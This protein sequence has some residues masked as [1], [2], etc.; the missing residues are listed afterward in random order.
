MAGNKDTPPREQGKTTFPPEAPGWLSKPNPEKGTEK[1]AVKDPGRKESEKPAIVGS[2]FRAKDMRP[3][4]NAAESRLTRLVK[5]RVIEMSG[6]LAGLS[7]VLPAGAGLGTLG[8]P[9]SFPTELQVSEEQQRYAMYLERLVAGETHPRVSGTRR[10]FSGRLLRWLITVLMFLAVGLP[11][12]S[13]VQVAPTSFPSTDKGA[14]AQVIEQLQSNVPVLVVFDYDPALSG[15]M[16]AL[17]APAMN[18]LLTKKIPLVLISTS[19]TGPVLAEHFIQTTLLGNVG[20]IQSGEQYI[21]LG[22]LAGGPAGMSYFADSPAEAVPLSVDGKF[23]WMEGFLQGI[24]VLRN[25][26]AIIILTD[27]ADTGRNWI[28]QA[29]PHLGDV[30]MVMITSAQAGPMIRPYLD[31]AQLKGFVTGLSDAKIYEQS[32]NHPGLAHH[33]WNSFSTGMLMAEFL[34][35]AGAIWG[36]I[37]NRRARRK[38]SREAI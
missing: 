33:Y 1:T 20:Q 14:S 30:P 19:P 17:A 31:S 6:P 38:D 5:D 2:P 27:N 16:E 8:T 35:V 32:Y 26:S 7:G 15:E 3:G 25:F 29:G 36:V 12:A 4:K 34:I 18:Q 11:F 10:T 23:V 22:Y 28:E 21:N 13:D 37:A 24:R 9:P